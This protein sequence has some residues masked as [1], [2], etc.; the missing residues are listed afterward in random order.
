MWD[1]RRVKVN[2]EFTE[3]C[4]SFPHEGAQSVKGIQERTTS[5][6]WKEM[7]YIIEEHSP[8]K[9]SIIYCEVYKSRSFYGGNILKILTS[10]S[11]QVSIVQLRES[12]SSLGNKF[13]SDWAELVRRTNTAR[14]QGWNVSGFRL[15]TDRKPFIYLITIL[16]LA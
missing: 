8:W 16:K 12:R 4:Y 6:P 13:K 3:F 11:R 14:D 15:T 2:Q 5:S 10:N 7:F 9:W 1:M